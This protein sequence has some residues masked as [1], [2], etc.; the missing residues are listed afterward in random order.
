MNIFFSFLISLLHILSIQLLRI[1]NVNKSRRGKKNN[2][3][4]LGNHFVIVY[5]FNTKRTTYRMNIYGF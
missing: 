1:F 2:G 5:I 4:G 3:N